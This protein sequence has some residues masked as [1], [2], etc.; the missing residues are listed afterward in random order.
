[1]E[2]LEHLALRVEGRIGVLRRPRDIVSEVVLEQACHRSPRADFPAVARLSTDVLEGEEAPRKVH[3][4]FEHVG[5]VADKARR[6]SQLDQMLRQ[7][8][9]LPGDLVPA[10]VPMLEREPSHAGE[11]GVAHLQC[12]QRLTVA[13]VEADRLRSQLIE[14]GCGDVAQLLARSHHVRPKSIETYHDYVRP[15]H[16]SP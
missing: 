1:M 13:L 14:R 3:V 8:R 6:V 4:G 9:V 15:F 7:G 16:E 12:R 11:V 10:V 5:C 2:V